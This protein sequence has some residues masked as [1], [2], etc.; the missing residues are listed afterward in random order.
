MTQA[1]VIGAL[2]PEPMQI[3]TVKDY[4]LKSAGFWIRFWA[5]LIDLIV[6][7][8]LTAITVKPIFLFTGWRDIEFYHISPY[9][10]ALSFIFYLYFVVMTKVWGQT[11]GKMVFGIRVISEDGKPLTWGTILFR[12]WIGRFI[13][14]T[15]DILYL[16]VAFTPNHKA[17]HD[18]IA[19]TRVVHESTF[20]KKEKV[21]ADESKINLKDDH[22]VE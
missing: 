12:E 1:V 16:L 19:D 22:L 17:I 3:E 5:Y 21:I 20:E 15:V 13:S 18:Y 14:V 6:V 10:Y 4:Q 11:I 7:F 8:S 2:S 9:G